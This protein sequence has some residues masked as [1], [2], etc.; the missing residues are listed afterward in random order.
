MNLRWLISLCAAFTVTHGAHGEHFSDQRIQEIDRIIEA[1][2]V[3]TRIPGAAIVL[4][5]D[6]G[7]VHARG[8]G[9]ADIETETPVSSNTI[10]AIGSVSKSF[11]ANAL[12]Q[13]ERDGRI[14]LEDPV[15]NHVPEFRSVSKN[16][17]DAI[18][19]RQLMQHTSGFSMFDGNRHQVSKSRSED[20]LAKVAEQ[21]KQYRL[22][23]HVGH[24]FEYSNANYEVLGN[25][26]ATV[27]GSSFQA[28]IEDRIFKPLNM[29][30]SGI[31]RD[32]DLDTAT[33]YRFIFSQPKAFRFSPGSALGPKGGVYTT[34]DDM[35]H[36]LIALMDERSAIESWEDDWTKGPK[37]PNGAIYGPGWMV[38]QSDFGPLA[39]HNGMNGGYS[40]LAGFAPDA[41]LG[42]A[43]MANASQGLLAG[44]V[45]ALTE[46][47]FA[48][49]F[50][51]PI[52]GTQDRRPAFI[53]LIVVGSTLTGLL[54][55]VGVFI[56]NAVTGRLNR[57]SARWTGAAQLMLP[58]ILLAAIAWMAF[59]LVPRL[60]GL[61]IE[62]IRLFVPDIGWLLTLVGYSSIC[63]MVIRSIAL[64]FAR[65]AKLR[66]DMS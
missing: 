45:S 59:A 55:W 20:A 16:K 52:Q 34:A 38:F 15:V 56:R 31:L 25:L 37:M 2:L 48:V 28:I 29:N 12:L 58:G 5:E 54:I 1:R 18:S 9:L 40:A 23:R 57:S 32:T 36:Y 30:R 46:D 35:G 14:F 66:N 43:I 13:L 19:I 42:F 44:D 6:G 17:S 65:K 47:A 53:Q 41:G 51:L 4:V 27:E 22:N 61:P 64:S 50:D 60:F 21:T 11:V 10:F 3:E 26:L 7:V 33:P 24:H 62:A 49:A 8:F 63:F 39:K